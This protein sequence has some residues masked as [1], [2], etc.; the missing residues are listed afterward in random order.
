M[1]SHQVS[2][3]EN[4]IKVKKSVLFKVEVHESVYIFKYFIRTLEDKT[5][6]FYRYF[7]TV[8]MDHVHF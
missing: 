1:I 6:L 2:I 3:D 8:N 5:K 7:I 4:E